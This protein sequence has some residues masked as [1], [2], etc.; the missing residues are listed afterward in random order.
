LPLTGLLLPDKC[1]VVDFKDS[2][3]PIA[4][5]VAAAPVQSALSGIADSILT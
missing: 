4:T 1:V 5:R 3:S 2:T